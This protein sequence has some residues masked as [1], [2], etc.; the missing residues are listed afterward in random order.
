MDRIQDTPGYRITKAVVRNDLMNRRGVINLSTY[1]REVFH[2][3]ITDDP[4]LILSIESLSFSPGSPYKAY[5]TYRADRVD[6][7]LIYYAKSQAE[8]EDVLREKMASFVPKVYLILPPICN[9]QATLVEFMDKYS[10]LYPGASS[11]RYVYGTLPYRQHGYLEVDFQYTIGSGELARMEAQ[12]NDE[13]RRVS[14]EIFTLG[15]HPLVKA[16]VAHNYLAR[17][18]NYWAEEPQNAKD[19]AIRQSAYG[20]LVSHRCVCQGFAEAFKRLMDSQRVESY[21][22]CGKVYEEPD[23]NHAWNLVAISS[24]EAFHLDATWDSVS[25]PHDRYFGMSDS[26]LTRLREWDHRIGPPAKSGTDWAKKA[27][28]M[29][30]KHLDYYLLRHID[31]RFLGLE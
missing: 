31:K 15:M 4:R 18:V 8:A 1:G 24:D 14:D 9:P 30:L 21:V 29:I 7:S 11:C 6:P 20:A 3:A 23:G 19:S 25:F 13:I 17:T 2:D 16:Y 27:K 22:L 28:E 5:V 26:D 10:V 12:L